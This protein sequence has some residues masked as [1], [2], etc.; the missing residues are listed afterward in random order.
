M[1]FKS[2]KKPKHSNK[3]EPDAIQ[4]KT[5]VTGKREWLAKFKAKYGREPVSEEELGR[6]IWGQTEWGKK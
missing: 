4:P 2:K 5:P 1:G 3:E 6:F